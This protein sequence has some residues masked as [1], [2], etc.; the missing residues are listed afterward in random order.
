MVSKHEGENCG[1]DLK[2]DIEIEQAVSYDLLKEKNSHSDN[3]KV[4][5]QNPDTEKT[6]NN[7]QPELSKYFQNS[8]KK[9]SR[10]EKELNHVLDLDNNCRS[11]KKSFVNLNDKIGLTLEIKFKET[12]TE[13]QTG[14]L[15]RSSPSV[16]PFSVPKQFA[17]QHK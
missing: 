11:M 15:K 6:Q 9:Q 10:K 13:K 4:I 17:K 1:K 3:S 5:V 14:N 8:I 7:S 2:I 12:P 16:S